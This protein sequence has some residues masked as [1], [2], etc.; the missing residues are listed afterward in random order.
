MTQRSIDSV[1]MPF[2]VYHSKQGTNKTGNGTWINVFVREKMPDVF[3]DGFTETFTPL[4]SQG[5]L[6]FALDHPSKSEAQSSCTK[7]EKRKKR[8]KKAFKVL[9]PPNNN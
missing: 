5:S 3:L 1:N 2:V 6:I 8:K 9:F 4:V 7:K